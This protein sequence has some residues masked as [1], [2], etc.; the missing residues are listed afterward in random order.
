M[1]AERL[2][3]SAVSLFAI[4]AGLIGIAAELERW[5]L[6][7]APMFAHP[8]RE[9]A[10]VVRFE[11]L[12][13]LAEGR[14]LAIDGRDVRLHDTGFFRLFF[15]NYFGSMEGRSPH[16]KRV[17]PDCESR[18]RSI[19]DFFSRLMSDYGRRHPHRRVVRLSL[20]TYDQRGER[21]PLGDYDPGEKIFRP[22]DGLCA[23]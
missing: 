22:A 4:A 3:L 14:K 20:V 19:G 7:C 21:S 12:A 5:P 9:G 8:R 10:P 23:R 11:L 13:E 15:A 18:A 16:T 6:T 1:R 17:H 2:L